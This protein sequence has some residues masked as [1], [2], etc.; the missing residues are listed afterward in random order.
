LQVVDSSA[1]LSE[2]GVVLGEVIAGGCAALTSPF[3]FEI[4]YKLNL[5]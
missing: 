3:V 5:A 1:E 2:M 4:D